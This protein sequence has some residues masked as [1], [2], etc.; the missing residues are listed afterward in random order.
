MK[1]GKKYPDFVKKALKALFEVKAIIELWQ[2][3][4]VTINH[5]TLLKLR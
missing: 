4:A 5:V 1:Y 3:H 2:T